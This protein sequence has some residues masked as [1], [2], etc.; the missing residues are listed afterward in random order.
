MILKVVT[1]SATAPD[2]TLTAVTAYSPD[3][4]LTILNAPV[5]NVYIL[6]QWVK[7]QTGGNVRTRSPRMV[8]DVQGLR[9]RHTA[10]QIIPVTKRGFKEQV[11][12]N[13]TLTQEISGSA[14]AGDIEI[15]STLFLYEGFSGGKFVTPDFVDRYKK[16]QTTHEQTIAT[17]TAG[18]YSGSAAMTAGTYNL[19]ANTLYAITGYRVSSAAGATIRWKGPDFGNYGIGGPGGIDGASQLLQEGYFVDLSRD[20]G[21][22]LI[23]VIQF[24]NLGNTFIDVAQDE[25][26]ADPIVTTYLTELTQEAKQ[27][28][29]Q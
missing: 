28:I 27:L 5:G 3:D 2:T 10:A 23:P 22:G 26:G 24:E 1:A 20:Y 25:N 11:F 16:A 12:Q 9:Y 19:K 18:G 13:D 29:R 21:I 4:S 6:K 7:S 15:V 8:N 17:G 14:T